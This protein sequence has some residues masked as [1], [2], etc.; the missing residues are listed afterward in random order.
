MTPRALYRGPYADVHLDPAAANAL[1]VSGLAVFCSECSTAG[2]QVY[3]AD[4]GAETCNGCHLPIRIG[5]R[6]P[7]CAQEA[8]P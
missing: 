8:E 1:D 5:D 3:H 7:R 2:A 4:D 6:C